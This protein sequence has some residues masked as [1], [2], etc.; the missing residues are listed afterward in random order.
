MSDIDMDALLAQ[1]EEAT[2]S[3]DTFAF[4]FAGQRWFAKDPIMGDDE[5][6]DELAELMTDVD[7]AEHYLGAEQY[8]KFV[9]AGGRA[10]IVHLAIR[11]YVKTQQAEDSQG[12]PTRRSV[13]S[14]KRRKR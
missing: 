10:G 13:S 6:K 4:T 2:G 8:E 11:E 14:A 3:A 1:R 12:R 7:V 5:W 9:A